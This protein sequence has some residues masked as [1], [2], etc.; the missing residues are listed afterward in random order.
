PVWSPDGTKFAFV[1]NRVDHSLIGIYD[2]ASR[3]VTFLAPSV[4]HDTSPTW[5]PDSK[6]IAFI[7]GPGTPF[8]QQ[9]HQG[10]GSIG[11]PDGPAYN[12]LTAVR[13]GR[14]GRG[15]AGRAGG[16]GQ[17][18]QGEEAARDRRPGL[19]NATFTGGYTLSFWVADVASGEGHEFWHTTKDD[20]SFTAINSIEWAGKDHV[21]FQA[22]P[23]EWIRYFTVRVPS[24][25][26]TTGEKP[27]ALTPGD[28]A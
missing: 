7:R 11:N 10:A 6:R 26:T 9:A 18:G 24:D 3:A 20:Q 4:D 25:A 8:G 15:V 2:I 23:D 17:R 28:D 21:I 22:E 19:F 5:S 1:S 27:T 13:G 14:G 16:A 12:P